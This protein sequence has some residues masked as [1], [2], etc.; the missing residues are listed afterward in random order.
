MAFKVSDRLIELPGV[1]PQV[2]KL[3]GQLGLKTVR[4]LLFYLPN[5][6][7]DRSRLKTIKGLTPGEDVVIH[8]TVQK[9]GVRKSARGLL[10]VQAKV[11]DESGEISALWF[12]QRY[13]LTLLRPGQQYY[14]YGQKRIAPSLG[15]PFFVKKIISAPM[16]M[17]IYPTTA[18]LNQPVFQKLLTASRGLFTSLPDSIPINIRQAEKLPKLGVSLEK[19]HFP[20]R[21]DSLAEAKH[22]LGFDELLLLALSVGEQKKLRQQH[23][24]PSLQINNEFLK[25]FVSSLPFT[26]TSGQRQAA[27]EIIKD[28]SSGRPMRRLLYGEVG[29]GKTAI[30]AIVSAAILNNKQ[31][32]IFLAPT[33]AL[34]AQH[35]ERLRQFFAPHD[36][37]IS[38]LTAGNQTDYE[39]ADCIVATHAVFHKLDQLHNIGLVVID[40]QHRFGVNERQLLLENNPERHILMMTA[41]PIPR[42]LAQTIFGYLDITY[43]MDK[44]PQQQ[45]ITTRRFTPSDRVKVEKE[46][47]QRL[48]NGEPGY[49]I[50]PLIEETD[51]IAKDLFSLERRAITSEAK[52]LKLRFPSAQIA[53]LHG[54]LKEEDKQKVI[55]KFQ[56]GRVDILVSTTVVEV[57]IDNP[58]ATWILIEEADRFGLSQLHQLRGRIGRGAQA[59]VCYLAD[60]GAL[61]IGQERLKALEKTDDGLV[62]A[63][64]DLRLRGPGELAGLDQSGLPPLKYADWTDTERIR[65][66]FAIA[67][68]LL[69]DGMAKYPVLKAEL[70]RYGKNQ[71]NQIII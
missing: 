35:A 42:S 6:L 44:P 53:I 48:E 2:E 67:T 62:L 57:G 26:L 13:I 71:P 25:R 4:D 37:S 40:E 16:I 1:G 7:E 5:R 46:I 60:S 49:V 18:G 23:K 43:L 3:L 15:N 66:V 65:R 51:E 22:R 38:L 69:D 36:F 9:V 61:S 41:T 12:N 55:N 39:T 10:I 63:E 17:P 28:L 50:C 33:T 19:A 34:A 54:R 30:A 45:K 21:I 64:E 47:K 31:R 58:N 20:N 70:K 14:F 59:S 29:S 24:I 68:Q 52:R 8:A 56:A 27:W 11:A 32:V